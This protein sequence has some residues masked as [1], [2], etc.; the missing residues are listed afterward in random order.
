MAGFGFAALDNGAATKFG[1]RI[2]RWNAFDLRPIDARVLAFWI[3]ELGVEPG[4]V[5]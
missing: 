1:Q 5:A 3:E 2:G 4:F